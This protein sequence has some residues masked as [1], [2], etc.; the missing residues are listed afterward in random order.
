MKATKLLLPALIYGLLATG[1]V[2]ADCSDLVDGCVPIPVIESFTVFIPPVANDTLGWENYLQ[3]V[4]VGSYSA[5]FTV[6]LYGYAGEEIYSQLYDT[7]A[8]SSLRVDLN[9]LAADVQSG[10][11]TYSATEINFMLIRNNPEGGMIQTPLND[12]LHSYLGFY[13]PDL[14][15]SVEWKGFALTNFGDTYSIVTLTLI[16]DGVKLD[17]A[18]I[19]VSPHQTLEAFHDTFFAG[20]DP[21]DIHAITA[22]SST[23]TLTGIALSGGDLSFTLV[24]PASRI[25]KTIKTDPMPPPIL[26][27]D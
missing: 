18:N 24:T 2:F 4:N 20:I 16:G 14:D 8:L 13:Y 22:L 27:V 7:G 19:M 1:T 12:T 17:T 21:A 10:K 11:I 6:V 5:S 9:T 15:A 26:P 3:A 23:Q 25:T